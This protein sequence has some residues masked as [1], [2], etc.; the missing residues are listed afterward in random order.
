MIVPF[1]RPR[2]RRQGRHHPPLH[3]APEPASTRVVAL[4]KPT[5]ERAR[6]VVLPALRRP[7]PHR[8]G[9]RLLRPLLVQPRRRRAGLRVLHAARVRAVLRQVPGSSA[10][11]VDLGHPAVQALVHRVAATP[12]P[13]LRGTTRATRSRPGSFAPMDR[14]RSHAATTTPRPRDCHARAT[15][16]PRRPVDRD[17][18]QRAR[19]PRLKSIPPRRAQPRRNEHK[20]HSVVWEPDPHVAWWPGDLFSPTAE[21]RRM[22]TL[23]LPSRPGRGQ[24]ARAAGQS[25]ACVGAR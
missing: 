25:R 14:R 20:D 10:S 19:R 11:L 3:R 4:P 6:P 1:R 22:G 24:G 2:R 23:R 13:A 15:A 21:R 8:R 17:Q 9:D 7:S 16:I 12:G 18:L 5:E